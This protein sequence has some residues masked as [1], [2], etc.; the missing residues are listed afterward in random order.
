M[1]TMFCLIVLLAQLAAPSAALPAA[2]QSGALLRMHVIAQDDTAEMQR[3]KLCV[4]DAVRAVYAAS[5]G[6]G[7]MLQRTQAILPELTAAAELSAKREGFTGNVTVTLGPADF[8]K[9][10]LEG[11]VFPAGEYPALIIRLGSA[12]GHNWWGLIDPETSLACAALPSAETELQWDWS[13]AAL[14]EAIFGHPIFQEVP[15]YD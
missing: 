10:T 5:N 14:L 6:Q 2:M 7:S 1:K 15:A 11:V 9:R 3:V 13:F 8:D 12:A 4:R